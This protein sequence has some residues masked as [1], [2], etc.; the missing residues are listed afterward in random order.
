[1]WAR[2][3]WLAGLPFRFVFWLA[4]LAD[5]GGNA[6]AEWGRRR[7]LGRHH[8][9]SHLVPPAIGRRGWARRR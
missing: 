6:D 7:W 2:L 3:W 4:V 1:M 5:E 8:P 9:E